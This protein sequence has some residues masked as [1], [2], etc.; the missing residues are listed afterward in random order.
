MVVQN[1]RSNKA[2]FAL[3]ISL[4]A[5]FFLAVLKSVIGVVANSSA[6]LADGINSTSDVIYLIFVKIYMKFADKPADKEHPYGHGQLESIASIIVGAFVL[7]TAVAIFWD[8]V[9]K[10]YDYCTTSGVQSETGVSAL[11]A[12][13]FTIVAKIYL[14]AYTKKIGD[15]YSSTTVTAVSKDHVNDILSASAAL[16]GIIFS[17]LGHRWVDSVAGAFVAFFIL[18][19][20]IQIIRDSS[21]ELMK[22][23]PESSEYKRVEMAVVEI[24]EVK[25]IEELYIH[26]FGIYEM[27]NLCILVD[28]EITVKE[29]DKIADRVEDKLKKENEFIKKV[30]VHV[31]PKK[32]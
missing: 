5:N 18:K 22:T 31:H 27:V 13:L 10:V 28:G 11:I 7:T 15:K 29:G 20:G 24:E 9:N 23:T 12:A 30:N 8:S 3:S 16:I 17:M 26:R 14:S 19:T 32:S 4:A 21:D 1:E 2:N 25:G 6:L